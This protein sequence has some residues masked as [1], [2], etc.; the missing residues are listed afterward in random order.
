MEEIHWILWEWTMSWSIRVILT[1]QQILNIIETVWCD[2]WKDESFQRCFTWYKVMYNTRAIWD[3]FFHARFRD[4]ISFFHFASEREKCSQLNCRHPSRMN[5]SSFRSYVI[6][7]CT[8]R[9]YFSEL[10][11]CG[12]SSLLR[13]LDCRLR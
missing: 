11:N 8:Y 5:K 10:E 3:F 9:Q 7:N 4:I 2:S 13:L 6:N 1:I 12:Y